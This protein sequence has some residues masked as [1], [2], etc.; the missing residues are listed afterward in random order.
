MIRRYIRNGV[1]IPREFGYGSVRYAIVQ[2]ATH[3]MHGKRLS[4]LDVEDNLVQAV[5]D[6]KGGF[7]VSVIGDEEMLS[8]WFEGVHEASMKLINLTHKREICQ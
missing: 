6:A 2:T 7:K 4:C 8:H 3:L 1:Q 5:K